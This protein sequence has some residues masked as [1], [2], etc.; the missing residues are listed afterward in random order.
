MSGNVVRGT[1]S[2]SGVVNSSIIL[3]GGS[4]NM[5]GNSIGTAAAQ[6]VLNAQ[7][8][9]LT[10]LAELNGGGTLTK[11]TAGVLIMGNGN[12][13]TGG[14]SVTEGTLRLANT[15]GSATGSGAV[16]TSAGTTLT[17]VGSIVAASGNNVTVGG[18]LILG[19]AGDTEGRQ[20]SVTTAGSGAMALNGDIFFDLFS[21][22]DS[23]TLNSDATANDRLI[24]SGTNGFTIGSGVN[25]WVNSSVAPDSSWVIGT[26]WRLFDW[27]ALTGGVAGSFANLPTSDGNFA[28]LPDLSSF[29]MSWDVSQLYTLGTITI[30]PEP[31]RALLLLLGLMLGLTRRRR[32]GM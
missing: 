31:S 23:G 4:L 5:S 15:A 3:N 2:G 7:S 26:S 13:Y 29:N 6:V 24:L 19:N 16:S 30:V 25:L 10:N 22:Y 8:G 27:S 1:L 14:T 28:N 20:I 12:A 17:G 18:S 11:T 32:R 9:T 21:G